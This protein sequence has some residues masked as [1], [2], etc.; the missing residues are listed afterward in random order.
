MNVTI[1]GVYKITSDSRLDTFGFVYHT[2][3][4]PADTFMNVLASDDYS[5]L[6][7]QFSL[8]VRIDTSRKYILVVTTFRPN[9]TGS[10]SVLAEGPGPLLYTLL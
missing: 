10:F 3:F 7:N 9:V 2:L 5:G 1:P 6:F 8:E 4:N